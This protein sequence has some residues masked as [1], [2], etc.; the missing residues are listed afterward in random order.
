[1]SDTYEFDL[2]C[3]GS[4][5]ASQ[6][7]AVQAAKLG[8]RV[9]VVE[10]RRSVGGLCLGT[11]TIPSKTF[12]EAVL[13]FVEHTHAAARSPTPQISARPTADQLLSRV[14]QVV[15]HEVEVVTHQLWRNDIE[16][17]QGEAS[18]TDPHTLVVASEAGARSLTAVAILIAVG[19][20]PT[21]PPGV[22]VD[23]E[24]VLSSDDLL[25][26]KR[27]PRT[28]VV[29]GAGVIGIEYASM[30]AAL[31]VE[32]TLI[33]KRTRLLDFLDGE[34]VEELLHQMRAGHVTFRLGEAVERIELMDGPPAESGP[35]ARV[36]KS[37]R[38]GPGA[39][40]SGAR[41]RDRSVESVGGWPHCRRAGAAEGGRPVPNRRVSHLCRRRC[42]RVSEPRGDLC[43]T[44][45]I[46]G[47]PD[48]Q[49][50]GQS[51]GRS[52]SDR[53]LR[54]PRDLDGRSAGACLDGAEDSV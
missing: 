20:V 42:D 27:L 25:Q 38:V 51:H 22:A 47:L 40:F 45:A 31:G 49:C 17:V 14:A 3:I 13:S 16:L 44:G 6:R 53:H 41:R 23:G 10:K 48:V 32:V 50:P 2:V 33:D 9:A 4:G 36:R 18:F 24:V 1:M 43:G 5:P 11:G 7:A 26:L 39:V 8:K 19:T 52:F 21:P 15:R 46:G 35:P 29:V 54:H 12:R 37:N 28:M 30:F 34:I